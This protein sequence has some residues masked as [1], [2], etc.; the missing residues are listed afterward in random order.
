MFTLLRDMFG[1]QAWADREQWRAIEAVP[2]AHNDAALRN[3]LHHIHLVQHSFI[4]TVGKQTTPFSMTNAADFPTF[5]AL[6]GY[7]R[8]VHRTM[9]D[10]F[11]RLSDADLEEPVVIPWFKDRPLTLS[12]AEALTQAVMHSQWHRGQDSSRLRDLGVTP[13]TLDLIVWFWIGKPAAR[14]E[15]AE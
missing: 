10:E 4:W 5:E 14:W 1:H 11:G 3:R 2:A 8:D 12:R 6:R 9:A 13:P 15:E 7:A